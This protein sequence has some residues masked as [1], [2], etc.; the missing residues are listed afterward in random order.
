M[1][2]R[3]AQNLYMALKT[4]DGKGLDY[5]MKRFFKRFHVEVCRK[6]EREVQGHVTNSL[7]VKIYVVIGQRR[8][9]NIFNKQSKR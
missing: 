3:I 2:L 4:G 9:R 7:Q 1:T 8:R 6:S 5:L